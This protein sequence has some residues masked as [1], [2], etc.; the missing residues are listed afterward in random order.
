MDNIIDSHIKKGIKNTTANNLCFSMFCYLFKILCL[1]F[2][3]H[4]MV[5]NMWLFIANQWIPL[6]IRMTKFWG[7]AK[8]SQSQ[9]NQRKQW[10]LVD[11]IAII[12]NNLSL[13][14]W[15]L[16]AGKTIQ[17]PLCKLMNDQFTRRFIKF[18][19]HVLHTVQ[20]QSKAF[21]KCSR[22]GSASYV[23]KFSNVNLN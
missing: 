23:L 15:E 7:P 6:F 12:G 4:K 20:P 19:I 2:S 3:D 8:G 10:K 22:S 1:V 17:I 13:L 21:G 11:G 9:I 18:V 14:A 16:R 5:Q